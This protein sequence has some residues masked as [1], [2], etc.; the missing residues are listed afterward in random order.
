MTKKRIA[1]QSRMPGARSKNTFHVL[2]WRRCHAVTEV[3]KGLPNYNLNEITATLTHPPPAPA[4]GGQK[5]EGWKGQGA[6]RNVKG[7]REKN[8]P[9]TPA[10][11]GHAKISSTPYPRKISRLRASGGQKN[12]PKYSYNPCNHSITRIHILYNWHILSI[13]LY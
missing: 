11:G 5:V 7:E 13:L 8:P 6:R 1:T 4:S 2:R 9:P 3:D 12:K 10:S